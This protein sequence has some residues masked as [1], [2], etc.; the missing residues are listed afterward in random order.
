VYE[1]LDIDVKP[2]NN[3]IESAMRHVSLDV[4]TVIRHALPVLPATQGTN[5]VGGGWGGAAPLPPRP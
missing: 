5:V 1:A 2:M 3:S 4:E